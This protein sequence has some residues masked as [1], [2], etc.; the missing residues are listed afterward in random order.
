MWLSE[1]SD[2]DFMMLHCACFSCGSAIS[3]LCRFQTFEVLR[4]RVFL[5]FKISENM[6]CEVSW[7]FDFMGLH[8]AGVPWFY[9]FAFM[10]L[11]GFSNSQRCAFLLFSFLK[12]GFRHFTMLH[13]SWCHDFTLRHLM[14]SAVLRVY[15]C[16]I[17]QILD[18]T[19]FTAPRSMHFRD[20]TISG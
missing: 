16:A 17:S 15:E 9:D 11:Y 12:T 7:F 20:R 6:I 14:I 4:F 5:I 8:F 19:V 10:T 1:V 13:G 2:S 3:H 18:F